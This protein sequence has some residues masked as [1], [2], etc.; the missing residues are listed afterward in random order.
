MSL[1]TYSGFQLSYSLVFTYGIN[2]DN[3]ISISGAAG[4]WTT[5]TWWF[6]NRSIIFVL[7]SPLPAL[8]PPSAHLITWLYPQFQ[9][10]VCSAFFQKISF[11]NIALFS[12]FTACSISHLTTSELFVIFSAPSQFAARLLHFGTIFILVL[13]TTHFTIFLTYFSYFQL[14]NFLVFIP[15]FLK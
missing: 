2:S 8:S 15:H 10:E 14:F 4:Y 1:F 13:G 11:G 6:I 9:D 3:S 5:F 12:R 7:I